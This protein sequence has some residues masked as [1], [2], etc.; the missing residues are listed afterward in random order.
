MRKNNFNQHYAFALH[1]IL[2]DL[3]ELSKCNDSKKWSSIIFGEEMGI[4]E[5]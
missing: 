5:K 1:Q 4:V 3:F 2:L